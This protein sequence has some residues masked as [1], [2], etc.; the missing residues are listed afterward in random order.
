MHG[1]GFR[2]AICFTTDS[3]AKTQGCGK[4]CNRR[5]LGDE[6]MDARLAR[7]AILAAALASL[8][9]SY[10]T[11]N[12]VVTAPTQQMA[13]QIGQQAETYRRDLAVLWLAKPLPN[14]AQ[15]CPITAQVAENLG[16]GGATSFM[17]DHGEVFG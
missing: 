12:F 4:S 10:R 3:L 13:E 7:A 17:F 14:W 11:P 8:G 1:S 5:Q 15:P 9:A 16:A 2:L 6:S